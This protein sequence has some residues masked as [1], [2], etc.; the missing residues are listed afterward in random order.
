[1]SIFEKIRSF[2]I[3]LYTNGTADQALPVNDTISE[4]EPKEVEQEPNKQ[5]MF[6][7]ISDAVSSLISY[8]QTVNHLSSDL[9]VL[10]LTEV[11][12]TLPFQ[13]FLGTEFTMMMS[14]DELAEVASLMLKAPNIVWELDPT[15]SWIYVLDRSNKKI[16]RTYK[17]LYCNPLEEI[18]FVPV[19]AVVSDTTRSALFT[20]SNRRSVKNPPDLKSRTNDL[21]RSS[22]EFE[23]LLIL[24]AG[25]VPYGISTVTTPSDI[26]KAFQWCYTNLHS[27]KPTLLASLSNENKSLYDRLVAFT[28]LNLESYLS[29]S[30]PLPEV[31]FSIKL[32]DTQNTSTIG[33]YGPRLLFVRKDYKS[34]YEFIG[35]V[36][37]NSEDVFKKMKALLTS[38]PLVGSTV[39]GK[40][41][42]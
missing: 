8:H 17:G 29:F 28:S 24:S 10:D 6:A 13:K 25:I 16:Y 39:K 40:A 38:N 22:E 1:M 3:R 23:N 30:Q 5:N 15:H 19:F 35:M 2:I 21:K 18:P 27:S 9:L 33:E 12:K 34:D 31:F 11:I 7:V 14:K 4:E 20:L 36:L 32:T 37:P 41:F 26:A 42:Y